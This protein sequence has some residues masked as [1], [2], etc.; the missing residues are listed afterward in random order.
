M[1]KVLGQD[2]QDLEERKNFLID[3][4]DAVVEMDY[5]K[6]FESDELAKKKT[7][8]AEKHIRIATLEEQIKDF[9]DKINIELKPLREEANAL[10]DDIKSKG[11]NVHEKVYQFLDEEEKM[12]GFYNAEGILISSRPAT[13]DELQ[14]T[15]YADLREKKDGTN[16]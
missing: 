5:H 6:S 1:L 4:A 15:I 7:E 8:F 13:K 3:N 16:N 14:K 2:I 10:R 12:V 9:K 11:R